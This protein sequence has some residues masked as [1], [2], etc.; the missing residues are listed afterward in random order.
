[1]SHAGRT[2]RVTVFTKFPG[3]TDITT[4]EPVVAPTVPDFFFRSGGFVF[5][6]SLSLRLLCHAGYGVGFFF[7]VMVERARTSDS[8]FCYARYFIRR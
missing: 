5:S 4:A 7:H 8:L 6:S 1:M 3:W 2:V